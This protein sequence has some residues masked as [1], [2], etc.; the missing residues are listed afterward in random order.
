MSSHEYSFRPLGVVEILDE[1]FTIYRRNFGVLFLI[2]AIPVIG[3][4]IVQGLSTFFFD[5]AFTVDGA[6]TAQLGMMIGSASILF[7]ASILG[8]MA[9][10]VANG[11]V[12]SS[13]ASRMLG[14]PLDVGDSY[15]RILERILPFLGLILLKTLVAVAGVLVCCVGVIPALAITSVAVCVFV[16]E[17]RGA[18]DSLNRS[19]YL[20]KQD[21]WRAM[22]LI[23]LA[24]LIAWAA[25]MPGTAV[26]VAF[27]F[28]EE[29][30]PFSLITSAVLQGVIASFFSAVAAPLIGAIA[31]IY[32]FDLRV[33]FEAFDLVRLEEAL[34]TSV[35]KD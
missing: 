11:A 24:M 33:R 8:W 4:G 34:G 16:V 25:T 3:M 22:G 19:F 35:V 23:I 31:M 10:E 28:M 21:F 9:Q 18:I 14:R 26:S 2:C 13:I 5:S 17:G 30:L 7:L 15:H 32:Y 29:I 20:V 12:A 6:D 1:S 27:T